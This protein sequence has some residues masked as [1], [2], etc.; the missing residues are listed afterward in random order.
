MS[1]ELEAF[2]VPL[3]VPGMPSLIYPL[4]D[5]LG[6]V[7]LTLS[8]ELP[9]DWAEHASRGTTIAHV[10]AGYFGGVGSQSATV[11]SDGKIVAQDVDV[12]TALRRLGVTAAS[13]QDEWDTVGLGRFRKTS[14]WAAQALRE[15]RK[16]SPNALAELIEMLRYTCPD[17]DQQ[18]K[19]R[20]QAAQDLGTLGL[21]AAGRLPSR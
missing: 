16:N 9:E 14:T 17:R 18:Q 12:N 5:E 10:S 4:T 13:G 20:S 8:V 6:L 7:P 2:I 1:Y 21:P 3:S 15:R 19:V 11:W